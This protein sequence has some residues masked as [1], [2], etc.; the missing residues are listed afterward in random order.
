MIALAATPNLEESLRPV[1]VRRD[2]AGIAQLVELCFGDTLDESGRAAIHEMRALSRAGP[3]LWLL[4]IFSGGGLAWQYGFVYTHSGN[5]VGNVG[6]QPADGRQDVWLFANVA[7]HPEWRRKG[8]ARQMVL[9]A[10]ARASGEGARFVVLQVDSDNRDAITLYEQL[11][12]ETLT[13]RTTW[14]RSSTRLSEDAAV[15]P[16]IQVRP[17]FHSDWSLEQALLQRF[18][19]HGLTWTAPFQVRQLC[20]SVGRSLGHFFNGRRE[21]RWLAFRSGE[22]IGWLYVLR[23]AGTADQIRWI[24]TSK[25][26]GSLDSALLSYGLDRLGHRRCDVWVEHP[27]EE[28]AALLQHNFESARTLRWMQLDLSGMSDNRC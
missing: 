20:P 11:G 16:G 7:V 2:L 18:R 4:P 10:V 17:V 1:D 15:P 3:L 27:A 25:S 26:L 9:A 13:V 24:V 5:V 8:I 6:A 21:E 22:A 19:P 14:R 23:S 12:F 28:E